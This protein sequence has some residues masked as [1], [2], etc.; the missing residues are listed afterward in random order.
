MDVARKGDNPSEKALAAIRGVLRD[1]L[2][3][4]DVDLASLP[5]ITPTELAR[6]VDAVEPDPPRARVNPARHGPGASRHFPPQLRPSRTGLQSLH[7]E[8]LKGVLGILRKRRATSM[9]PRSW[10]GTTPAVE[11]AVLSFQAG[12]EHFKPLYVLMF[13]L[14]EFELGIGTTPYIAHGA[15]VKINLLDSVDPWNHFSDPL[16]AVRD[17]FNMPPRGREPEWPEDAVAQPAT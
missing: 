10:T 15:Q 7:Q 2:L 5:P 17:R 13:A 9:T 1:H 8:G 3:Q 12:F 16:E 11:G 6:E 14:A 4:I